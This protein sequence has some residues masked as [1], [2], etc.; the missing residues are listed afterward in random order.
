MKSTN[1]IIIYIGLIGGGEV[2]EMKA[3]LQKLTPR[4]CSG[5]R[6]FQLTRKR[7]SGD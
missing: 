7:K 6:I 2:E 1:Y 4:T 5:C 3:R